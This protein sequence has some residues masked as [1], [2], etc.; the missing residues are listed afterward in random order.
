MT[1]PPI[2]RDIN[3]LNDII[4]HLGL[5]DSDRTLHWTPAECALFPS[6][7]ETLPKIDRVLAHQ[8]S[9][10]IF[11]GIEILQSMLSKHNGIKLEM[12]NI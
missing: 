2:T 1:I 3:H 11:K 12:D 7:S 6:A 8:T 5:I 10:N 4:A 9:V